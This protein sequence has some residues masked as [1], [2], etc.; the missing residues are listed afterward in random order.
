MTAGGRM[1][2]TEALERWERV[3]SQHFPEQLAAMQPGLDDAAI[4]SLKARL[5]PLVLPEQVEMLYRWRNGGQV[6]L[7]GGWSLRP[8]DALLDWRDFCIAHLQFPPIWLELFDD[9]CHVFVSLDLDADAPC[10]SSVWYGHTHDYALSRLFDDLEGL[11]QVCADAVEAGL[12]FADWSGLRLA[13]SHGE[14]ALDG[15]GWS[16]LRLRRGPDTFNY[17]DPPRGTYRSTFPD[18]SWPVEWHLSHGTIGASHGVG[19]TIAAMV[20]EAS[21]H[22][23]VGTIRA[24]VLSTSI[25]ARTWTAVVEDGTGRLSIDGEDAVGVSM[26]QVHGEYSFTVDMT[27]AVPSPGDGDGV[28]SAGSSNALRVSSPALR[29]IA[30]SLRQ[31]ATQ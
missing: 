30:R 16:P 11:L 17:P 10:D 23:A 31:I 9:Q 18:A 15:V 14:E 5:S 27:A 4:A 28:A 12:L 22:D 8:V 29:T 21:D 26:P 19:R 6:G 3:L 7:F 20:A 24:V 25:A 2:I 1:S 13:A